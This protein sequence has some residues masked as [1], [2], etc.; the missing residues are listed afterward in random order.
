MH[1][2]E[3]GDPVG[4][5]EDRVQTENRICGRVRQARGC[6]VAHDEARPVRRHEMRSASARRLDANG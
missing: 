2:A 5:E 4:R 6:Q 3:R 1:F